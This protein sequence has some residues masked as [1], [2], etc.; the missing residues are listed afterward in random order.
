VAPSGRCEPAPWLDRAGF[1]RRLGR[2]AAEALE[3]RR[4]NRLYLFSR[5]AERL[6]LEPLLRADDVRALA[7]AWARPADPSAGCDP[8]RAPRRA[9]VLRAAA[10]LADSPRWRVTLFLEA[11][12]PSRDEALPLV[13]A[14][15][16]LELV[17]FQDRALRQAVQ[18]MQYLA[19][20]DIDPVGHFREAFRD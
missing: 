10:D 18:D 5:A 17:G 2:A 11:I 20:M 14:E 9:G 13:E 4:F 19:A 3:Q 6:G 8:T 16:R 15:S 1:A 12:R 7:A